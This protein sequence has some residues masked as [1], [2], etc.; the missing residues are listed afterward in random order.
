MVTFAEAVD[1]GDAP[2]IFLS[3]ISQVEQ[4][5]PGTVRFTFYSRRDNCNR[6]VLHA[7]WD[8]KG[9][10]EMHALID[11]IR[12]S[13]RYGACRLDHVRAS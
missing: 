1:L 13:L 2:E 4:V 7:I 9:W 10:E 8:A 12:G 5:G 6:V 3:G 11:D